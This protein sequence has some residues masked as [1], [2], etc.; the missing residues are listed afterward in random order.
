MFLILGG[1]F[2][3]LDDGFCSSASS[4][5]PIH[6]AHC[7]VHERVTQQP[8]F[9]DRETVESAYSVHGLMPAAHRVASSFWKIA[10][11]DSPPPTQGAIASRERKTVMR[12]S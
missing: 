2:Q 4:C 5:Q 3:Q 1:G 10:W 11:I 6:G 12:T 9:D 8:P 7:R